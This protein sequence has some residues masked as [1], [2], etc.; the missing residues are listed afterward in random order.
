MG[1][2]QKMTN[3]FTLTQR[4]QLNSLNF[5]QLSPIIQNRNIINLNTDSTGVF[6]PTTDSAAEETNGSDLSN[7]DNL[8]SSKKGL[9]KFIMSRMTARA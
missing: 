9:H 6:L 1:Y 4:Q 3:E 2:S 7:M 5:N 8:S